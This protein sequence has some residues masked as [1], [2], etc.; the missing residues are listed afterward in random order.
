MLGFNAT[1]CVRV[2][3]CV[4]AAVSGWLSQA[5]QALEVLLFAGAL[6]R[7]NHSEKASLL[8]NSC[9]MMKC[10]S[11][12]SSCRQARHTTGT[13][14][15]GSHG[16]RALPLSALSKESHGMETQTDSDSLPAVSTVCWCAAEQLSSAVWD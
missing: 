7:A 4:S 1:L 16:V 8:S 10:S 15:R 6:T 9:G 12:H 2:H 5:T 3:V 14:S 11:A 13:H